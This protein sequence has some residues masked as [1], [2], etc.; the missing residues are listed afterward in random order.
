MSIKEM[1][2]RLG[3]HTLET[4]TAKVEAVL[5]ARRTRQRGFGLADLVM[6]FGAPPVRVRRWI[7][8][9]LLG[10]S[11]SYSPENRVSRPDLLRFILVCK[12]DLAQVHR[13]CFMGLIF[14]KRHKE[15]LDGV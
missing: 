10:A 6:L 8:G 11:R 5:F 13:E 12:Y 4:V 15:I 7:R 3:R 1:A 2:G 14:S 9:G